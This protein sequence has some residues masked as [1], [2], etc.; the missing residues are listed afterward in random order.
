MLY[1]FVLFMHITVALLAFGLGIAIHT[2]LHLLHRAETVSQVR[3][4]VKPLKLGPIFG[5]FDLLLL[6]L[7]MWLLGLSKAPDK[8]HF[9]DPFV[10]SGIA[11]IAYLLAIGPTI[12]EHYAKRANQAAENAADGPVSDELRAT[13]FVRR[14]MF[15]FNSAI[16]VFLATVFNMANKPSAWGAVVAVLV[17]VIVGVLLTLPLLK[18]SKVTARA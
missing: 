10:W 17:G 16:G 2:C 6:G 7:G 4:L 13:L 3:I 18:P 5:V 1:N 8:F 12:L 15:V 9:G 14:D 11:V